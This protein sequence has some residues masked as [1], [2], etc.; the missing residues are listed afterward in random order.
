MPIVVGAQLN[1]RINAQ[2]ANSELVAPYIAAAAYSHAVNEPLGISLSGFEVVVEIDPNSDKD[3]NNGIIVELL[4]NAAFPND[5]AG[6]VALI[7][8][9]TEINNSIFK[10]AENFPTW[11]GSL[12]RQFT[13]PIQ[14]R[15]GITYALYA[16]RMNTNTPTGAVNI[17][18]TV[19]GYQNSDMQT[20]PPITLR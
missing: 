13:Y 11:F 15:Y 20:P 9:P 4:E 12:H 17:D 8:S 3:A 2:F 7:Y 5:Q 16:R 1:K 19:F 14:L 6:A 18:L 10:A